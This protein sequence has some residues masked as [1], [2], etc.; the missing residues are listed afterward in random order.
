MKRVTKATAKKAVR[1]HCS[2]IAA[3]K[4]EISD[5]VTIWIADPAD[6]ASRD[7]AEQAAQAVAKECG[8]ATIRGNG[9]KWE[10]YYKSAPAPMGDYMDKSSCWHY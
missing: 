7:A 6:D 1:L 9:S 4:V 8:G 10:V 5:T 2:A 3:D